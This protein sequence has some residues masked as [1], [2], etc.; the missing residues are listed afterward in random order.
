MV[1]Q[2]SAG[3]VFREASSSGKCLLR[4]C[5]YLW[6]LKGSRHTELVV[7]NPQVFFP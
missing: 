7:S 3:G 5:A 1:L 4:S 6:S 2:P